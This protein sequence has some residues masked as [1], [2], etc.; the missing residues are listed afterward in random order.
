MN[1]NQIANSGV[2]D[3]IFFK[4]K[5][6]PDLMIRKSNLNNGDDFR[7]RTRAKQIQSCKAPGLW[8][9]YLH[10]LINGLP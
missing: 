1:R 2:F 6:G 5:R 10:K 8:D 7:F 4:Q 3:Y 9:V